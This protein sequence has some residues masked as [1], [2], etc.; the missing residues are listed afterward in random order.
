MDVPRLGVESEL[1]LPAYT[2]AS[3]APDP[4]HVCGLY[5]SHSDTRSKPHL[6]ATPQL[7]Q[8]WILVVT[9][10][11]RVAFVAWVR[12]LARDFPHAVAAAKKSILWQSYNEFIVVIFK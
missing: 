10:V 7:Q 9:V 2:T 8:H 3:A 5:H 1:Q 6:R 4:S 11:A 12:S